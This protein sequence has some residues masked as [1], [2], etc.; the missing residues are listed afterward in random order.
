[1]Q[2]TRVSMDRGERRVGVLRRLGKWSLRS[3]RDER[4]GLTI[5]FVI[6]LPLLLAVLAIA[7]QY[8]RALQARSMLESAV[9]D[10][11]LYLSQVE[12]TPDGNF[13]QQAL[14]AAELIVSYRLSNYPLAFDGP[15]LTEVTGG[16]SDC[17]LVVSYAAAIGVRAPLLAWFTDGSGGSNEDGIYQNVAASIPDQNLVMG[18]IAQARHVAGRADAATSCG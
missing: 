9:S 4:G 6:S 15:A 10:S 2:C 14:D 13:P 8:G 5:D 11:V 1:M 7:S 12:L 17:F 18:D 16:P 3:L